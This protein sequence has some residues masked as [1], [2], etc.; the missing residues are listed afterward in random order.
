MVRKLKVRE[1]KNLRRARRSITE[2]VRFPE[3]DDRAMALYDARDYRGFRQFTDDELA[4]LA[5]MCFITQDNV[6]GAAYDDEVFDEIARRSTHDDIM[7]SADR[8]AGISESVSRNRQRVSKRPLR[9]SMREAK[10]LVNGRV[11]D[12]STQYDSRKSFYGKAHVVTDDDGTQ[13]L[14]SYNTPVVEIKDGK[15]NLLPMWDSS[16]TTLRHVKEFLQQNGFSVGSKAE[17]ARM[18]GESVKRGRVRKESAVC[19]NISRKSSRVRIKEAYTNSKVYQLVDGETDEII[20]VFATEWAAEE[21]ARE[22]IKNW[23]TE[24]DPVSVDCYLIDD[25]SDL[26]YPYTVDEPQYLW[27]LDSVNGGF[28]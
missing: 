11:S 1:S 27:T 2:G 9:R 20:N 19:K 18:Y 10:R 26:E 6:W 16:Q 5:S 7:R 12:L 24:D 28:F 23:A 17:I 4:R 8:Y 25:E 15:V 22:Y 21:Y 14:Y 13:T 3:L